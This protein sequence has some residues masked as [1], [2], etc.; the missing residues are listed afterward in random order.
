MTSLPPSRLG[1]FATHHAISITFIAVV[2]CLAGI[3]SARNTPSSVFPK[4][5]FPR[6]VVMVNNGIMPANE[7][8]ATITRP[9][10]DSMK[11]IPGVTS[12]ISSTM[13]GA[14]VINV[15]FNWGTDMQGAEVYVMGRLSEIRSDLPSTASTDVSRVA[16]SLSYPII[17][18]SLTSD[19]RNQMDLWDAATYKIKPMFL[20]I[21]GVAAVEILG[22]R[23]PEYHVVVDPVKLQAAHL[24][25][26]DV[27]DALT[28]NNLVASAGL[29][30]ENYH[31]YLTMVDGRVHSAADIGNLVIAVNGGHP[32]RIQDVATVKPG[33]AP[34]Y[35]DITAQG[36]RAVLFN[37]ES[38]PGS[39]ILQIAADL[40]K[41]MAQLHQELP[42]DMHMAFFYDQS[43]FVRDSVG[44]VWDAIIFGLILSVIILFF[45]LKNW[46][47]VWTAIVTIPISVLITAVVMKLLGMSFNMMTLG[48]IAA[49][50]GLII[51][52][53]IV[54]VEAMCHRLVAGGPRLQCIHE[55]MGEILTA[56][57]GSTLTPVVVFLP[58][59]YLGQMPGVFFR[60]LGLTMVVAL[61]V[62]LLLAVTL[63]PSLAAW[64]IRGRTKS[65]STGEEAGFVLRPVLRIYEAAIRWALRHAWLTLLMCAAIFVASFFIYRQLETDFLPSFD[66]GGFVMDFNAKPGTSLAEASRVLDQVEQSIKTNADVEGYS[67]RLGTQLGPFITEP[68]RGD[69][70]I[71]LKANRKHTTDEVLAGMRHDFN[72]R[73]PMIRWDFHGYLEDLMGDL[74]M[75]P[76]PVQIYLYSPDL[77]WLETNAPRVEAQIKQIP[78]VV[79]TFDGLTKTGPSI[80]LRVRPTDAAR[81]GL[82][83]QSVADAVNTALLGQVSSYM[84]QGDRLVNI[85]VMADQ[86]SVD[87][88]AKLRNLIIRAPGGA[89]VRVDQVADL[90]VAPSESELNRKDWRQE[91]MVS[92]RLEGVDLGT[93]MREIQAKLSQDKWLPSGSVEYGGLYQQQQESFRNL[94]AVLLAAILL[95]FTVLLIE[96]RSFYEPIA[97]VFGSVLALFGALAALW[98]TGVSLNIISYLGMIIGVGIVAKNGILVLDYFQQLRSQSVGLVEALVQA[99]HRRLRPVLMTSLAAALGMLPLAYGAGT[100]AQML[101][102][103]GVAVIGALFISVLLSLIATPVVY[104]LL[105]RMHGLFVQKQPARET[106]A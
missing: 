13:R 3:F 72:R 62:S 59:A 37:I 53:A 80:N 19:T 91:D 2:L 64:L 42:P 44:S 99:G 88:I 93:G 24:A 105:I 54:V 51:D 6:V 79:D 61:L 28:Q 40:K 94:L 98:I 46:G 11:S 104:Y 63:T 73:F 20:R 33:P 36:H 31:L 39:S 102:P 55:A 60:A 69:Y 49:S 29:I 43:Q 101:Q 97:I 82:T 22:G 18:I 77:N 86:T 66:E 106:A 103:L 10:E 4:T 35:T 78:G 38:Q 65:G 75:N 87:T 71:K 32:I 92:A 68:Y 5:P 23:T 48:G 83:A 74:Q 85:R 12:V 47:S 41:D 26:S 34:A 45:F 58:L 100:G 16:F 8:M 17:G 27:R 9:I 96:F 67:R 95:V 70:L 7:M 57:V 21:P 81:F 76:D 30:A 1:R 89:M 50:I 84:L 90:N 56:L 15:I 25:L 14:A 52:N